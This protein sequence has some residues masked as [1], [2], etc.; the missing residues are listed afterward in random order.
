M[1]LLITESPAKAKKIQSFLNNDYIV[2]S[3][4]GHI[5]DLDKKKTKEYGNPLTFGINVDKNFKP[6]YVILRDKKK[7]VSMLK[8]NSEGREIILAAD[9]DR[10]GE[11]IA[12]HTGIVLKADVKSL[13]RIIFRE[14]SKKEIIRS[15]KNPRTININQVNSQQARRIIDRLIGFTISPCLWKN[16]QTNV[17]GLSAG[18]VQS[19]LLNL[20]EERE[21]YIQEYETNL[22]LNI[23]GTFKGL[24]KTDFI[25]RSD[26]KSDYDDNFIYDLMN[27]FNNDRIFNVFENKQSIEKF[28]PEKPFITSTLQQTS[29]KRL[30]LSIKQTMDIAQSLYENGH[31]TYM[32]TDSTY[33]SNEFREKIKDKISQ[34][35]GEKYYGE[36]KSKKVIGAQEAHEA[37][38]NTSLKKPNLTGNHLRLYELI[39]DRT[40]IS[41]MKPAEYN[42]YRISLRN[43]T[44]NE[45]GFFRMKYPQLTFAG[46]KLY[47]NPKLKLDDTPH[48]DENYKL[49]KCQSVQ[50][51]DQNPPLYD[52]G[53]I[54]NLLEKTGIGRP[55]TYSSIVS[56][57]DNRNYTIKK[58][59][60][61]DDIEVATISMDSRGKIK[62]NRKVQ[63]G[64]K[65]KDRILIT[66]LGYKVLKYL[67]DNF[68][69][70]IHK[71]FTIQVE[72]DLDLIAEGKLDYVNVI[73]KVYDSFISTAQIQLRNSNPNSNPNLIK[74][75]SKKDKE[76][77]IGNGK[78]GPYLHI[79]ISKDKV[80]NI[81]IKK[82]MDLINKD[83]KGFTFEDAVHYLKYPKNITNDISIHIGDNGYYMKNKYKNY[84]LD[85]TKNGIYDKEYCLSIINQ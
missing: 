56:T 54:V 31:I 43:T 22:E 58:N 32:R 13:K 46:F 77:Y 17:P 30:G 74:L 85:Q 9:D 3:S 64:K 69:N 51:E 60:Q 70:I 36:P 53:S 41:H 72:R 39:Y 5:R 33:I 42:V 62:E 14:I 45:I 80:K 63:K 38:R 27:Q 50:K 11:A 6:K 37:V 52:E 68:M 26:F 12:W 28:Y 24:N 40:I 2:R 75:G 10:E 81:T 55:S 78:Y 7:V 25:I 49:Q 61:G 34:E 76:I 67:Q 16:I 1:F 29:K 19:A 23:Y 71:E 18:R 65:Y 44:T 79:K 4:C 73:R 83:I 48:F 15:L 66:P 47:D 8:D 20:L 59:I 21:K 57:L 35:Y 82:Y 84:T